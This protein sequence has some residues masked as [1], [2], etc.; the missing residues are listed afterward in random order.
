MYCYD[1][2]YVRATCMGAVCVLAWF[3][4]DWGLQN[5]HEPELP[6]HNLEVL[7]SEHIH[8]YVVQNFKAYGCL[9][10]YATSRKFAG[11]IPD[12]VTKIFIVLILPATLWP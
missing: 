12:E 10:H 7:H 6:T 8:T 3:N 2:M 11:S 4:V 5:W 1:N 9:K